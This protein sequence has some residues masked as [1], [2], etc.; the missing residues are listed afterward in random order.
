VAR[1]KSGLSKKLPT[2]R[3]ALTH[4]FNI[5]G[6]K[7]YLNI[8]LYDD[9]APGEMFLTMSKEGSTIGGMVDAVA[10]LTSLGLQHGV[11]LKAMVAKMAYK[12]FE[13]SGYTNNPDIRNA[14][15]IVDYVFRWMGHRF[16][17]NAELVAAEAETK[18]LMGEL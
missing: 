12:R 18:Q 9:G 15:S 7:G 17:N 6:N 10:T 8:G 11:P 14:T 2:T 4:K 16:L 3:A 13:P 5:A 1:L